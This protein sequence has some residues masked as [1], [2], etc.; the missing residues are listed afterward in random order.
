ME[1]YTDRL[2]DVG[3]MPAGIWLWR[4]VLG[5]LLPALRLR[6]RAWTMPGRERRKRRWSMG[7]L[8]QDIEF[9]I[10][11][12][13]KSRT[14]S[15][16]IV[17]TLALGI[18][19]NTVVFSAV[20]G[21]VLNPFPFPEPDA[22]VGVG[23][24]YPRIG[25]EL[26]YFENL[27]PA[28]YLDLRNGSR[29]LRDVVAW[30]MGNR[31]V[32]VGDV[33]E[34]LFSGFWWGDAFP[35]LGVQPELGRGFTREEIERGERVAI[36]SDR[37]WRTRFNGDRGLVGGT[38]LV[39]GDPYT[40]VGIMPP[41]TLLYGMDLWLPMPVG[42]E[43][44]PRSRRQF[45]VLARLAPDASLA[46]ANGDLDRLANQ[47]HQ[48]HG[49]EFP[50][51]A[52]W[53]MVATTWTEINV[54][55]LKPAALILMGAVGF[56]LLLV[57]ANV[58]NL[59]LAR[60]AARRQ[61][62]AIRAAMGARGRRIVRQLL[63]ESVLLAL[64]GGIAGIGL[65]Y[66]GVRAVQNILATFNAPIPGDVVLN[67]RVLAFS[68]LVTLGA[69]MIFGLAPA[70]RMLRSDIQRTLRDDS[71]GTT[72][73]S[74]LRLQRI[75]VGVEVALAVVLLAGGGLLI[76]SFIR[77]QA[78]DPG[79]QSEN[80]LTM[81]LTLPRERYEGDRVEA[82]F[83]ELVRRVEEI[84]G[85]T[86]AA[87]ASQFPPGVFLRSEFWIEGGELGRE[88]TLPSGFMT[89]ASPGYFEALGLPV[90][91]GRAFEE[92]DGLA[93]PRVAVINE[94]AAR[95]YFPNQEPIGRRL[96]LGG[97]DSDE[98]WYD[99]VG[100]V[101]STR[102]RG[103]D[104]PSEPE[105]F[106]SSRQVPGG[107]NQ[108]FLLIRTQVEP[109]SV[110]PAVRTAVTSLDARQPVYAIQTVDEAFASGNATR[111]ISTILLTLFAG[112]A[113]LLA[114]V[115]I[116]SVVS[117]AASQRT[118]EIGVR[119]ALGAGKSEVGRLIVRQAMLPVAL[120]SAAGLAIALALGSALSSLL[121]EV[122][123]SDPMTFASVTLLLLGIA[124]AA[125]YLP[126]RR[127]SRLHPVTALRR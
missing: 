65:G 40:V 45:Q 16:V 30:D 57:C 86:E 26:T 112:F 90:T 117:Y 88:G 23:T 94:A 97:P 76:R 6:M 4:Q 22:L 51:Y 116:Y 119:M 50:E 35:T 84:P 46:D 72:G 43:V 106:A 25:Q 110:L 92:S 124:V 127:A 52:D 78:V 103:L 28:E 39:N 123:A 54:R 12:I 55:M 34:N 70:L 69:G 41:R 56:V 63:T 33:T 96:K 27:S 108:L 81:R 105:L 5:S 47:V 113:L 36:L 13:R 82:F 53:R 68:A 80:L 120:G 32:T 64:L 121:F 73:A 114:A 111:R 66:F 1:E 42:P 61:E 104:A 77:L 19:A 44:F 118:R 58:T 14:F 91:R 126:A 89:I 48:A 11:S 21:V 107:Y 85:V 101:S 125:S 99:V 102:N 60:T 17:G 79:F 9:G 122:P 24:E 18:A 38:V 2:A 71:L 59:L 7:G 109:R 62:F 74:R 93:S 20:D 10:R 29:A 49:A 83:Q 3:R 67:A 95:R 75:I 98:P 31:Q 100:V 87:T 37:V 115:G 15:L 8:L